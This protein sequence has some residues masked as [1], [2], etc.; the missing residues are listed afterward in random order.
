MADNKQR[1]LGLGRWEAF[2]VQKPLCLNPPARGT[3]SLSRS[4]PR[5]E[6]QADAILSGWPLCRSESEAWLKGS[7]GQV[8]VALG[9]R[10]LAVSE[11]MCATGRGDHQTPSE[12]QWKGLR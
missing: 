4:V 10:G 2:P 9:V 12:S 11:P 1:A 6:P 8:E 5:R 7:R 3:S